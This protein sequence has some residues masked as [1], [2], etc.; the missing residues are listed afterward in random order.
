MS[1]ES[2]RYNLYH[3]LKMSFR[4]EHYFQMVDSIEIRVDDITRQVILILRILQTDVNLLLILPQELIV[5]EMNMS[6]SPTQ[7]VQQIQ[8]AL[9]YKYVNLISF[10]LFLFVCFFS[11]FI[12]TETDSVVWRNRM[13]HFMCS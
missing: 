3:A 12:D 10:F 8:Y 5:S 4:F 1:I 2:T 9:I 13:Q 7:H 6:E 11:L